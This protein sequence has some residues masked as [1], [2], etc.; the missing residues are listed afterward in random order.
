MVTKVR[1]IDFLP[2]IFRTETNRQFLSATLDQLTQQKNVSAV[3]GYI[4]EKFG[5]GISRNDKYVV[6]PD[7]TRTDYQLEPA[8]IFLKDDTQ[9]PQ[10]FI[11]YPGIVDALRQPNN[12]T[13]NPQSLFEQDSY[14]W[15]SFINY[16][17]LLNYQQYYWLPLGPDTVLVSTDT[18]YNRRTYTVIDSND[19]YR[20][21]TFAQKNPIITLLRGGTYKFVVDGNA[22]F[23][24]Q[25]VPG[26]NGTEPL[27]PNISTRDVLGVTNNGTASGE[28]T[29]TVPARDAQSQYIL[30]GNH[31]VDIICT[32]NYDD[33]N[34]KTL[35]DIGGS[36][37]G[38][39]DLNGK[40]I[41][42]YGPSSVANQ[43]KYYRI[44]YDTNNN[45]TATTT[46]DANYTS[47]STIGV[48]DVSDIYA[49]MVIS[50]SGIPSGT[51]VENII[52]SNLY[53]SNAITVTTSTTLTFSNNRFPVPPSVSVGYNAAPYAAYDQNYIDPLQSSYT[54]V[55]IGFDQT[56]VLRLVDIGNIPTMETITANLGTV[57]QARKFFRN[58]AGQ[59]ELIP[60][61]SAQLDRLYYQNANDP[62]SVGIIELIESNADAYIYISDILGK[63][64]Y[65][66]PNKVQ[67]TNGLKISFEGN[68]VP[69]SY[70]GNEYYV[71]GVGTAIQLIPVGDYATPEIYTDPIFVPYDMEPYDTTGYD[72]VLNQP[73]DADYLTIS[74]LSRDRNAWSRSNR[75]FHYDVLQATYNYTKS[76][77]S[78]EDL[79]STTNRAK[80]PIIEFVPNLKLF[81]SGTK[82]L[83]SVDFFDTATTDL[84]STV[85]GIVPTLPTIANFSSATEAIV[86]INNT[87][88]VG[89]INPSLPVT[90]I[91]GQSV[92]L[93]IP[94]TWPTEWQ[95]LD[96]Q[97]YYIYDINTSSPTVTTFKLSSVS[98]IDTPDPLDTNGFT[99]PSVGTAY[100]S[101]GEYIID[102]ES[103]FDGAR[104][105]VSNDTDASVR[106]KVYYATFVQIDTAGTVVASFVP[107]TDVTVTNLSQAVITR[108]DVSYNHLG[109]TFVYEDVLF[110][111]AGGWQQCQLKTGPNQAPLFDIL[112]EN[113]VSFSNTSS[114]PATTFAGTKLFSYTENSSNP[115][116]PVLGFP[117]EYTS[118]ENTSDINFTV[119]LNVDTFSYTSGSTTVTEL[120]NTGYVNQY[121][122]IDVPTKRIGWVNS[123]EQSVQ[124]QVFSFTTSALNTANNI[125]TVRCDIPAQPDT[126]WNPVKV[127]LN[128][129]YLKPNE[130]TY[131]VT[132]SE[133]IVYIPNGF[134][135][136]PVVVELLSAEVSPTAYYTVPTNLENNPFNVNPT[137]IDL[138]GIR[139]H[140]ISICENSGLVT[141]SFVGNNNSRDLPN[142]D[143]YGNKIIQNSAAMLLP[144]LFLRKA[145]YNILDALNFNSNEY[146]NYKQV[147][148]DTA[149][150]LD[151]GPYDSPSTILDTIVQRLVQA[152]ADTAPF[153][154]S[155]MYFSGDPYI[156]NT[157]RFRNQASTATYTL[158]R[159]YDFTSANYYGLGIY[160]TRIIDGI[161]RE[162]QLLRDVNWV[163]ST[164]SPSVTITY[165]FLAGDVVTVKEYNQTYGTFCPNTPSK[166]GTYPAFVP[167]V[168]LDNTYLT[169]TYFIVGHDGSYNKLYGTYIN[170]RLTDPRDIALFEFENRVWNNIKVTQDIPIVYADVAPGK[171]RTTSYSEEEILQIK[172]PSFLNWI[173][174][175]RLDYR[176]NFYRSNNAFSYNYRGSTMSIDDSI[177]TQGYWR[178]IYNWLYD[179]DTP[180]ITPWKML[181]FA[182]RPTWWLSYYGDAPY[183]SD[184]TTLWTD[185]SNGFVWNNGDSYTI[186]KY[187]RPQLLSIIPVDS[188]GNLVPPL[189]LVVNFYNTLDFNKSW[190]PGDDSPTE[191]SYEKSS[192]YPFDLMR[193]LVLT[194]PAQ[195]F[196]LNV[197]RD[198]YKFDVELG[199]WLYNN[200][201]HINPNDIVVYGDGTPK[202][203]YINWVVDYLNQRGISSTSEVQV[204]LQNLDVRLVYRVGGFTAKKFLSFLVEKASTNSANTG[205]LIPD[206]S[207]NI[208]LYDNVPFDKITWSSVV[209]QKT[210]KGYSVWGNSLTQSFFTCA[211]PLNNNYKEV[212]SYGDYRVSVSTGFSKTQTYIVPYGTE[213]YSLEGVAEF[214]VR[215]GAHLA[216]QGMLFVNI[217]DGV[218]YNW[219][220]MVAEFLYW[221][222]QKWS[223]GSLINLNPNSQRLSINKD[224]FIV[225]P[226]TLQQSNFVLDQNMSPIKPTNMMI[227]R[228]G[229]AFELQVKNVG[230][231]LAYS[232]FNMSNIEHAIVFDNITL[233][234]D[235]IYNVSI[236]LRQER[237]LMKG[238]VTAEWNGYVDAQGFL[239]NQNNVQE[240]QSNIKYSKGQIVTYKG[241]YWVASEIIEPNA[242]F[243]Q[244]Q[245]IKSDYE[246]VQTGLLANPSTEAAEAL[247]FYNTNV[248]ALNEDTDLLSFSLIGFRPREYM[249]AA[250]LSNI[251]QV[252]IYKNFIK[253]KGTNIIANTFKRAE[254]AQGQIDYDIYENWAIKSGEFGAVNSSNFVETLLIEADLNSNP[255]IIGFTDSNITSVNGAQ[256]NTNINELINWDR[257]PS[258]ANFLPP[259]ISNYTV[260]QG[261]PTAGYV[262]Y[263]DVEITSYT[264]EGLNDLTTT[265]QNMYYGD[266]IWLADY[267]STWNVSTPLSVGA[268]VVLLQNNLN[269]TCTLTFDKPHGLVKNQRFSVVGFNS[270]VDGY[271]I[272]NTVLSLNSVLINLILPNNIRTIE[273]VGIAFKFQNHR[274]TQP[275]AANNFPIAGNE[276]TRKKIWAD[277]NGPEPDK[278]WAVWESVPVFQLT[279]L[280]STASS[281]QTGAVAYNST[282][283]SVVAYAGY[284]RVFPLIG[285]PYNLLSSSS[286]T[287]IAVAGSYIFTVSGTTL[288]IYNAPTTTA[289]QTITLSNTCTSIDTSATGTIVYVGSPSTNNVYQYVNTGASW[290]AGAT[291]T[292]P[293]ASGSVGAVLGFG[294]S[295]TCSN[296]GNK[297][298]VGAPTSTI[299]GITQAGAVYAFDYTGSAVNLQQ[300]IVNPAPHQGGL[301]G[302]SVS[303]FQ[304]GSDFIIGAPFNLQTVDGINNVEGAVYRYTSP[305][306][307]YGTISG[308]VSATY[309]FSGTLYIDNDTITITSAANLA[310]IVS[311]INAG[312]TGSGRTALAS[313]SGST[314]TIAVDPDLVDT[315]LNLIDISSNS[316]ATLTALGLTPYVLTQ[317]IYEPYKTNTSQ[318]GYL[319]A[320][321]ELNSIAISAPTATKHD[322]TT[323]DFSDDYANNDTIFDWGATTFIDQWPL[324]GEV[325]VYDYLPAA[326]ENILNTGKYVFAEYANDPTYNIANYGLQP[327]YGNGGLSFNN[328]VITVTS[329]NWGTPDVGRVTQFTN[330][331]RQTWNVI[332]APLAAVDINKLQFIEIYD[333]IDNQTLDYLDYIDPIQGKM[334][335]AVES[336]IDFI[337]TKDPAG[338]GINKPAWTEDMVGRIWFDP[339]EIR[340]VDTHQSAYGTPTIPDSVYNSKYWAQPFVGS[341]PRVYRWTES[342]VDPLNYSGPGTPLDFETYVS[343]TVQDNNINSLVTLYY[344]WVENNPIID[345]KIGKTLNT[346]TIA[347]YILNPLGSGISYLAPLG[348]NSVALFNST[349]YVRAN[350]SALHIGYSSTVNSDQ[351]HIEFNL[352]RE[353]DPFDFLNGVPNTRRV[354]QEE[355]K[356]LYLKFI[357]SFA[358]RNILGQ[359][360]PDTNLPLLVRYGTSNIYR[361]SMF[362]N[363][364]LALQNYID[365][366]NSVLMLYPITESRVIPFLNEVGLTWDTRDFWSYENYW[367]NGYS[368]ATKAQI[369]VQSVPELASVNAREGLIAYVQ[370]SVTSGNGTYYSYTDGE[371]VLIGIENGTIQFS[372]TL[373]TNTDLDETSMPIRYIVRA[374]NEQIF[375]GDLQIERNRSLTLMFNYIMSEAQ[376]R[377]NY[378]PWLNKTSLIDVSHT[379]RQLIPYEKFQRDNQDFLSGWLN[380]VKPYHVVIKDFAFRYAGQD[381]FE[382][383]ITDFDVPSRYV[384]SMNQYESPILVYELTQTQENEYLPT[385]PIWTTS[386]Y[387]NWYNNY[388]LSIDSSE[389][390]NLA[391]AQLRFF[392]GRDATSIY[393]S[394]AYGMPAIGYIQ[395]NDEIIGYNFID[396]YRGRLAGLSRARF[397]TEIAT[398]NPGADVVCTFDPVTVIETGRAYANPPTIDVVIDTAVFPEPREQAILTPIMANDRLIGIQV[399]D[400]GSGY[401]QQPEIIIQPAFEETFAA[402][403]FNTG[404]NRVTLTSS[405]SFISGDCVR[406]RVEAGSTPPIGLTDG[407]Y[408][409]VRVDTASNSL[410]LFYNKA[411]AIAR[412][413]DVNYDDDRVIMYGGAVGN[414]HVF[415]QT[416]RAVAFTTSRPTREIKTTIKLDRTSYRSTISSWDGSNTAYAGPFT[417]PLNISSSLFLASGENYGLISNSNITI[418]TTLPSTISVTTTTDPTVF[419]SNQVVALTA[420]S[421]WEPATY[422]NGQTIVTYNTATSPFSSFAIVDNQGLNFGG[423]A[424]ALR[425]AAISF[426]SD[427]NPDYDLLGTPQWNGNNLA[428]TSNV[429]WKSISSITSAAL[430]TVTTTTDH[431]LVNWQKVY[432]AN[433]TTTPTSGN[434][435]NNKTFYANRLSNNAFY[436]YSAN[437]N[438]TGLTANGNYTTGNII[439]VT[440]GNVANVFSVNDRIQFGS[441][442]NAVSFIISNRWASNNNIQLIP[443]ISGNT[444]NVGSGSLIWQ[445]KPEPTLGYS[446]ANLITVGNVIPY[447][448][449]VSLTN[450]YSFTNVVATNSTVYTSAAQNNPR[451]IIGTIS[452]IVGPPSNTFNVT[453]SN[454]SANNGTYANW[455]INYYITAASEG[456]KIDFANANIGTNTTSN[457]VRVQ[458]DFAN[459][460]VSP[461]QAQGQAINF[462]S[463][464]SN[465]TTANFTANTF[466]TANVAFDNIS[467]LFIGQPAYG[468]NI[469]ANTYIVSITPDPNVANAPAGTI[470]FNNLQN[471]TLSANNLVTFARGWYNEHIYYGNVVQVSNNFSNVDL[472]FDPLFNNPVSYG[473]FTATYGS[474]VSNLIAFIPEPLSVTPSTITYAGNVYIAVNSATG[475]NVLPSLDSANWQLVGTSNQALNAID[476]IVAAY[477]PTVNMVGKDINQLVEGTQYPNS[478]LYGGILDEILDPNTYYDSYI[479]SPRFT[480]VDPTVYDVSGGQFTDGYAPPELVA[481]VVSDTID[482]N[483]NTRPGSTWDYDS[484]TATLVFRVSNVNLR[485]NLNGNSIILPPKGSGYRLPPDIT[486]DPPPTL[487]LVFG[488]VEVTATGQPVVNGNGG[489]LGT[490]TIGP[491]GAINEGRILSIP[492]DNVGAGYRLAPTVIIDRPRFANNV[493]NANGVQAVARV[494]VRNGAITGVIITQPGSG[495]DPLYPPKV[496]V[497]DDELVGVTVTNGGE[498]Y[499]NVTSVYPTSTITAPDI[500]NTTIATTTSN[501]YVINVSNV[502]NITAG[503]IVNV[504][505]TTNLASNA[506]LGDSNITL[507]NVTGIALGARVSSNVANFILSNTY[508]ANLHA[509]NVIE[510]STP[511]ISNASTTAN[512]TVNP[513][514]G[515]LVTSV[516]TANANVNVSIRGDWISASNITFSGAQA[517]SNV[518]LG[519]VLVDHTGFN[520]VNFTP[521]IVNTQFTKVM[522]SNANANVG[523]LVLNSVDEVRIGQS[524]TTTTANILAANTV[525]TNVY[526]S[527]STIGI[528]A[529]TLN[530]ASAN[531]VFTFSAQ[532]FSFNEIVQTPMD[533]ILFNIDHTSPI[534]RN[535]GLSLVYANSNTST[536]SFNG[537][538]SYAFLSNNVIT[539][540][541]NANTPTSNTTTYPQYTVSNVNYNLI[542]NVTTLNVT[543]N[544]GNLSG[545]ANVSTWV[546]ETYNETRMV[547]SPTNAVDANLYYVDWT[548]KFVTLDLHYIANVGTP[549]IDAYIYEVGGGNELER[550]NTEIN[551]VR[552]NTTG[553]L[554]DIYIDANYREVFSIVRDPILSPISNAN[555]FGYVNQVYATPLVYKYTAAN[556]EYRKL[557]YYPEQSTAYTTT[558]IATTTSGSTIQVLDARGIITGTTLLS[559]GVNNTP[560]VTAVSFS[561]IALNYSGNVTLDAN[562][563]IN[564]G[565]FVTF[566]DYT[567][568]A[569]TDYYIVPRDQ[570]NDPLGKVKIVLRDAVEEHDYLSYVVLGNSGDFD[571]S[572][573]KT[574][575][576]YSIPETQTTVLS[577]T[578]TT[579]A[580]VTAV[581][582]PNVVI[583]VNST[584]NIFAGM[585]A[586]GGTIPSGGS[587]VLSVL[588]SANLQMSSVTGISTG[589]NL[590][591]SYPQAFTQVVPLVNFVGS[592]TVT[593][594][595]NIENAIVEVN[596][597]RL[598]DQLS[599]VYISDGSLPYAAPIPIQLTS[600]VNGITSGT[601]TIGSTT[602]TYYVAVGNNGLILLNID[603]P[604]NPLDWV[605]QI[606]VT[607]YNLNSVAVSGTNII[608]VGELGTWV[609][610]STSS[611]VIAASTRSGWVLKSPFTAYN[612]NSIVY[613][614]VSSTFV[615]VGD[616]QTIYNS[617]N[618][619]STWTNY[620]VADATI[621]TAGYTTTP[622]THKYNFRKIIWNNYGTAQS[623]VIVGDCNNL[624]AVRAPLPTDT[625]YIGV[626]NYVQ[627]III[628]GNSAGTTWTVL[629]PSAERNDIGSLRSVSYDPLT[630]N[631]IIVGQNN[632]STYIGQPWANGYTIN[633][634]TLSITSTW[635]ITNINT[636]LTST[637]PF[638]DIVYIADYQSTSLPSFY[639]VGEFD[640]IAPFT[641]MVFTISG[642][643]TSW[644]GARVDNQID[645]DIHAAI[646]RSNYDTLTVGQ[647]GDVYDVNT[648][649]YSIPTVANQV[650]GYSPTFLTLG[651]L[652]V[653]LNGILQSYGIDY[654]VIY[655][656]NDTPYV[657]FITAP[658]V[659]DLIEISYVDNTNISDPYDIVYNTG[660][661]SALLTLNIPV[662]AA[663]DVLT[664]TT[665]NRTAQQSLNTLSLL[666][667]TVNSIAS[668]IVSGTVA[669]V[670]TI[671]THSFTGGQIVRINR[672]NS[673]VYDGTDDFGSIYEIIAAPTTTTFTI[674]VDGGSPSILGAGFV[675]PD[676][677]YFLNQ[678]DFIILN[679]SRLWVTVNGYRV[680]EN[681]FALTNNQ[682]Q[683][684]REIIA[685]DEIGILSMTPGATPN[686]E[687]FTIHLSKTGSA[688]VLRMPPEDTTFVTD[689]FPSD[690]PNGILYVQDA[691]RLMDKIVQSTT[692]ATSTISFESAYLVSNQVNRVDIV[693]TKYVSG[694]T[695]ASIAVV[696]TTVN[697]DLS[698]GDTVVLNNVGGMVQVNGL[699]YYAKVSGYAAN[700]FALYADRGLTTALNSTALTAYT[701]GGTFNIEVNGTYSP[702][703]YNRIIVESYFTV[704]TAVVITVWIGNTVIVNGEYIRF[705]QF[706]LTEG[707]N[708]ISGLS[709]GVNGTIV[710]PTIARGSLV[711]PIIPKNILPSTYY[712][713]SWS[714]SRNNPLQ[715]SETPAA[716]FL[717]SASN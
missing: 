449:I 530:A 328:S 511:V 167:Q 495:Y 311:Q 447:I 473:N 10:D 564:Y 595:N 407:A 80:R 602:Y 472:Y 684:F 558:T 169:P 448:S 681:N 698:D 394:N 496:T 305:A 675:F 317:T 673:A 226:L 190:L 344:F 413:G 375:I 641:S 663:G 664:V 650:Y 608:V 5:Y 173:G 66:S 471:L 296:Q 398:H 403:A 657:E 124:Y 105:I 546:L 647:H 428:N 285:S 326:N 165:S 91:E 562:V 257:K 155:D 687:F 95:V 128:N 191:A 52:N 174:K 222:S 200:R 520:V 74:R 671:N 188:M 142:L 127:Y 205:L 338:Y 107:D 35:A 12:V 232:V 59:I 130:F 453:V 470:Q 690:P 40:T 47:V 352:I 217:F 526:K 270:E 17:K 534:F 114:Y 490:P 350:N 652:V 54:P 320:M 699:T 184:N 561:N 109:R 286:V 26:T 93:Q 71:E 359:T 503:M 531:T 528:S 203:S 357:N 422:G 364:E 77:R 119:N 395:I 586:T 183:T 686:A 499:S 506:T 49:G 264:Y 235:V 694:I 97:I 131:T 253:Q 536:L 383:D 194:K 468:G 175:N 475:S 508:V 126:G 372:S 312:L 434:V 648:D 38:V 7:K 542:S 590:T 60:Y 381:T 83:G 533:L 85:E 480:A 374:I 385:N 15:E 365:Y 145:G 637:T 584:A 692:V 382:G 576:G 509:G 377:K 216:N 330:S 545:A 32:S 478:T 619:G 138:G 63:T 177:I 559:E 620:T 708:S 569:N 589:N 593:G 141:G 625:S 500:L 293:S 86:T 207:Y 246:S 116:D 583:S 223:V 653:T 19:G 682:V 218:E 112:N 638:T 92:V 134:N 304:Y 90:L 178:G 140:W 435:I 540:S 129:R 113:G 504:A 117:L 21:S 268:V 525:V 144:G 430:A 431:N 290:V 61:L 298:F 197:D 669:T 118:L 362:R 418:P 347:S 150:Q 405:T 488:G 20:I 401:G 442:A 432:L 662:Q 315:P 335:G 215:Y 252:N 378:L 575:Y 623:F 267:L 521:N 1:T 318:F 36:I 440:G 99:A 477:Q 23:W 596:G 460:F 458:L 221:Q 25:G 560:T 392:V 404:T 255:T 269:S 16:D 591:F 98:T 280:T 254:F 481:G 57:Y 419:K 529:N 42:F 455:N 501:S 429:Y 263:D 162:I 334:F 551:P 88:L 303:T 556:G 106:S 467:N 486:I 443:P 612:L 476:R 300:T 523:T 139:N 159:I 627:G 390:E 441:D 512:I 604:T 522:T 610:L 397:G 329:P 45:L 193:L 450:T 549:Y 642:S 645:G 156:T 160:V 417:D 171:F 386:P 212:V 356:G 661:G 485:D 640:Q 65:T 204:S 104:I 438:S 256:Q 550:T 716:I 242:N 287:A 354:G 143:P 121:E 108:G 251:S 373:Y 399:N 605:P 427:G 73:L 297:L 186:T 53:L 603:D 313:Y 426:E 237:I 409:Y 110:N 617:A 258:T 712:G 437:T 195:F 410:Y 565:S 76:A 133:T 465:A 149:Y 624:P 62:N 680:D 592:P 192:T 626:T 368:N 665:F 208:L 41:M 319:V 384:N 704:G 3:Q 230:D 416:A 316:V 492:I 236:G 717:R 332:R 547:N 289:V 259:M 277:E 48:V 507:A 182:V 29:F 713:Y 189:E 655:D 241:Q 72:V 705:T 314:L 294:T 412:R 279:T 710:S 678:P 161:A 201:Y 291:I 213:F 689:A 599:K 13:L 579:V 457:G 44:E 553:A 122:I 56:I 64:N 153:F 585:V 361:Q 594:D 206:D 491:V 474:N 649:T 388:G 343:V 510:L 363:R 400:G 84:L 69:S 688:S 570:A 701:S 43:I 667:S 654:T 115:D 70:E 668:I 613:N 421:V 574:N 515:T 630:G 261:I 588:N 659:G 6:E 369:Q 518:V 243:N 424:A 2:E 635:S 265:V 513:A 532:E 302:R 266:Y 214:L 132:S 82:S 355:P 711:R 685:S 554:T 464:V 137:T 34:G 539:F 402:T 31:T 271:Y 489:R 102:G 573:G 24:I 196:N 248:A 636:S 389:L 30:P 616:S 487:P 275:S 696:T 152:K 120:I 163:T 342:T 18:V 55:E 370:T 600:S 262:N 544:V 535:S 224:N 446:G 244:E 158:S 323:F 425:G 333:T 39:T 683:I 543:P 436:L 301:F 376:Q 396:Y 11:T 379:I 709:R 353:G 146:T 567:A 548:D 572:T 273:G 199:Q 580:N 327:Q 96:N 220:Q 181:G 260:Q 577:T 666:G 292:T 125:T 702:D 571:P 615:V 527:N 282:V 103:V 176:T 459:S 233:F 557:H 618:D 202:H 670:T 272:V 179:T 606:N 310:G 697:H 414:G 75:W 607:G 295:V 614:A 288:R 469:A 497:V 445:T 240:W 415:G 101:F 439:N 538:C 367:V 444:G 611:I 516:D 136:L 225:Q 484:T 454:F 371:W 180:N 234:N 51:I 517:Y 172:N 658:A 597:V 411:A 633:Y 568:A 349:N 345:T 581:D 33:I 307:R 231:T 631:A 209:V 168:L 660:L 644:T 229:T 629:A 278:Q 147:I 351:K 598:L 14:S 693:A 622:A 505:Y 9:T 519:P 706:D 157:Y 643:G 274:V 28:I 646:V 46:P 299:S 639:V 79:Q 463:V 284:V 22:P 78:L 408:Y 656:S 609:T 245:W 582:A 703:S 393:I 276:F 420:T 679:K 700:Q 166:L 211:Q 185:L 479:I 524:I 58:L 482:I 563:T 247:S 324:F 552:A 676:N 309:P 239:L 8:V 67:F 283:G 348:T 380:E 695:Q 322:L 674:N 123:I 227:N 566:V 466:L 461:G 691:A 219:T 366:V 148:V 340:M 406:Y 578:G 151:F 462:Y 81:D 50:G 651:T 325:C 391:I 555:S 483:V 337:T 672:T 4:G 37:D 433:I 170:G 238:Y 346:S 89:T 154:W 677:Q 514:Y 451:Y 715:I 494:T 707:T 198:L 306:Q 493:I 601:V 498:G 714:D 423:G 452:N 456:V 228:D 187:V 111:N 587:I 250:D 541:A 339:S 632:A 308:V 94:S 135:D 621:T 537:D 281:G 68:V 100:A 331:N 502:A 628:L 387:V 634:S 360:V 321:N 210:E 341:L 336:N 164:T 358:G 249:A 27:Y 87:Q